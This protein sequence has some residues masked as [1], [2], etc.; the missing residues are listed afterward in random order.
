[1]NIPKDKKLLLIC[2]PFFGYFQQIINEIST[3]GFEVDYYND[4]PSENSFVK[5]IIKIKPKLISRIAK[6]Y[7]NKIVSE[8]SKIQY[9]IILIINGKILNE[10]FILNLR[11]K[12]KKAYFIFYTWDAI[13][14]YPLTIEL[15]KHFDICFSFDRVDCLKIEG[16]HHLPLFYSNAYKTIGNSKNDIAYK[17]RTLDILSICTTHPNRYQILIRM[18]PYLRGQGII[19]YSYMFIEP[20]QYIYNK[21]YVKDFQRAKMKEFSIRSLSEA[22]NIRLL[23]Q[24]RTVL[25]IP[26]SSQTGLT[27]RTLEALGSKRKLITYNEEI[28]FYD[29]YNENNILIINDNHWDKIVPF[30]K[31][32][33]VDIDEIIYKK[34]SI[35]SWVAQLLN[36]W[37]EISRVNSSK[38]IKEG[39]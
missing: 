8:T 3:L 20:F 10:D 22:Q 14:L 24:T 12:Q 32:E 13:R 25:D 4:R 5:G 29:F 34:Y 23:T 36:S 2:S 19:V 15:L 1:M 11:S 26:H 35:S 21:F 28:K 17:N 9:D 16:L 30:L 6:S 18:L 27:I 33:F 31:K 38:V 7:F 37:S 39:E